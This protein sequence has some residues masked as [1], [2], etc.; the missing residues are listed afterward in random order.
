MT[1]A[2][3]QRLAIVLIDHGSQRAEANAQLEELRNRVASQR[4][5]AR[6]STAH[7]EVAEPGLQRAI[8]DCVA[9]GATL[10]V[11]HPFFLSPGRHTQQDVPEQIRVARE[12]HPTVAILQSEPLGLSEE[13]VG[14]VLTRIDEVIG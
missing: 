12:R 9:E 3:D 13:L 8:D 6:V 11:V 2:G 4:P 7:L 10:I 5:Q 14:L 1:A